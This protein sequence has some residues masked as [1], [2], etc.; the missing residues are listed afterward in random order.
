MRAYIFDE[1]ENKEKEEFLINEIKI[2][3]EDYTKLLLSV[4]EEEVK[5]YAGELAASGHTEEEKSALVLFMAS[6]W[7]DEIKKASE[8][9]I[10]LE[11]YINKDVVFRNKISMNELYK[12]G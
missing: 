6:R 1:E 9:K 8:L 11:K 5:I 2:K 3:I 4:S 7:N 12:R 10:R